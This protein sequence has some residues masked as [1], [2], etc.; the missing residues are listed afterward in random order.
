M[1][2]IR[3]R[4]GFSAKDLADLLAWSASR[5]SRVESGR[6]GTTVIDVVTHA[7]TCGALPEE[8]ARLVELATATDD[9]YWLRPNSAAGSHGLL[10]LTSLANQESVATAITSF[11]LAAL[12]G[13]LQIEGYARGLF[14]WA[15]AVPR[16][17][18]DELVARRL[19]R[20]KVLHG[21]WHPE[22]RSTGARTRCGTSSAGHG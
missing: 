12:P 9:G 3:E 11:H 21:H 7:A 8:R 15:G 13:L 4:G 18:I 16:D 19:D 10:G 6:R 2:R 5:M 17:L 14:E 20:Q 22:P 1:R